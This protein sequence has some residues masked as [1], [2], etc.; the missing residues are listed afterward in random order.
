[1]EELHK[2]G[3]RVRSLRKQKGY[4]NADQFAYEKNIARAQYLR[5]ENGIDLRFSSIVKLAKAFDM[6]LSEFF[7]EGFEE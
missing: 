1:M 4:T 7:G 3:A 5:Y 2:F 6:N